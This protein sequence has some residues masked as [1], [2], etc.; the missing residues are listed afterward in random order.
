MKSEKIKLT[1]DQLKTKYEDLIN[2]AYDKLE[3][4]I[5]NNDY[6]LNNQ[7]NKDVMMGL[8]M[9]VD[10]LEAKQQIKKLNKRNE[11]RN[12]HTRCNRGESYRD[13]SIRKRRN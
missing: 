10:A 6:Y 12:N 5:Q 3:E 13:H 1:K 11:K 9:Y 7:F 4:C 8:T 2:E